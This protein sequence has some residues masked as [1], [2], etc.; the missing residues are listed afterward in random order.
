MGIENYRIPSSE[1]AVE[2]RERAEREA[3]AL[4]VLRAADLGIVV[5]L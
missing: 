4:R 3:A 2:D 1:P 5:A